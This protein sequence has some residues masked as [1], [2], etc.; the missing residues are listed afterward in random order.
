[1]I[2]YWNEIS[3]LLA[4]LVAVWFLYRAIKYNWESFWVGITLWG[5]ALIMFV[6]SFIVVF[7]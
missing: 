4:S 2:P 3:K 1:M 5:S 6:M 7:Y